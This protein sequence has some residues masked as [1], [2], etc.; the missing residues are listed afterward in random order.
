MD[1]DP[2][3]PV[4]NRNIGFNVSFNNTA[5]GP[6]SFDWKVYIF[7]ADTPGHSNNE[8][9]TQSTQFPTG[10]S[11]ESTLGN[12]RYGA[13]GNTCEYFFARVGWLDADNHITYFPQADGNVFQKGFSVCDASFYVTAPTPVPAGYGLFVTGV[14]L[15]PAQPAYNQN[16][17]FNV[18]FS[19]ATGSDKTFPWKIYIFRADTS[20][21]SN[22]ETSL[23]TTTFP[24][25]ASQD[26]ALGSFRY[27]PTGYTCD[28]FYAEVGWLDQNDNV[29]YFTSPDGKVFQKGFAVCDPSAIP[30]TVAPTA[31][32]TAPPPPPGPGVFVTSVR[33][34]PFDTPQHKMPTTF[35]ATFQNTSNAALS[36]SWRILV[37]RAD[38]L[39]HSNF[40]TTIQSSTFQSGSVEVQSPGT[41]N[42]GSTGNNC[43][44]F[45]ARVGWLD[46]NNKVTFF[47]TPDGKVYEKG[48]QVCN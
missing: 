31:A 23:Q 36:F 42:Y 17:A 19:N 26:D 5:S 18:A 16:V 13:T 37:Y 10:A 29:T 35:F 21:H 41:F 7:R 8:T 25:G 45:I 47:T 4:F 2:A 32:P 22:N 28:Y 11:Q 27:G 1:L 46:S 15:S 40:D 43:D 44:F 30:T 20:S 38:T 33:L 12:F 48:F 39:G 14:T 24:N 34:Q 6:Q 3:Q 9:T